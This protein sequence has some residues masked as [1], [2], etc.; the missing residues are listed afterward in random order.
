M[1]CIRSREADSNAPVL[2]FAKTRRFGGTTIALL[3]VPKPGTKDGEALEAIGTN[4]A[5]GWLGHS[6]SI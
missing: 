1:S 4:G 2:R 5:D 3:S 6:L